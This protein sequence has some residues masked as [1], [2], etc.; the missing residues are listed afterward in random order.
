M[1]RIRTAIMASGLAA[2][3]LLGAAW[4][5][6]P[7]ASADVSASCRLHLERVEQ[8]TGQRIT[9]VEDLRYWLARGQKPR[10]CSE[11]DA[12]QTSET[13]QRQPEEKTDDDSRPWRRDRFGFHCTWRG[14]G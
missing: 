7:E 10:Y 8:A 13:R 1:N 12:Q 14:C 9:P 6:T 4:V 3:A 5:T 2:A 11:Q